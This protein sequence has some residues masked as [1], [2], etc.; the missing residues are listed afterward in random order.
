[1]RKIICCKVVTFT[2]VDIMVIYYLCFKIF[3]NIFLFVY[4]INFF[5]KIKGNTKLTEK[6]RNNKFFKAS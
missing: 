4:Y 5:T 2:F 3:R 6:I 1:M